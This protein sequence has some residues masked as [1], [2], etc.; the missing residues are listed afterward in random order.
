MFCFKK[1]SKF[2]VNY[3]NSIN[4]LLNIFSFIKDNLYINLFLFL[5]YILKY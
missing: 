4:D 1:I 3:F 2:F 5:K